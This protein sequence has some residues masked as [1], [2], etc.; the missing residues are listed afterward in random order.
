MS[1]P[2]A[3]VSL[4]T[5]DYY[6][7]GALAAAAALKDLHPTPARAPEVDFQTV[8]LVTPETV[9]VSTIKLLRRAF[10]VVVGV[11]L[12]E[13]EDE[14]GLQL[15]GRPDLSHVLTKLHVFRLTQYRKII[16]LDADVLPIRPLSHL[17]NTPHDFAAVP[18]VGWPDIF[19]SGVLVLTPGQ[20]K[21]DELVQLLKTKGSWDGG[22]QGL[23]NEWRGGNWHRLSFTY[24]TTPT[25]AYTYAPAYERFGSQISAIHFIGPNKPW[26]SLQ[27]RAPGVKTSRQHDPNVPREKRQQVYDF[28]SLIDRWFDVYDRYYRSDAPTARA[29]FE[30]RRYASAW[31][32]SGRDELGAELPP[33]TLNE[34]AAPPG[35]SL[36]LEDLRRI[37]VEGMSNMGGSTS[38]TEHGVQEGEYRSMPLEGRVDLMRP[39]PE[40]KSQSLPQEEHRGASDHRLGG[41]RDL[42]PTQEEYKQLY[43][44]GGVGHEAPRMHTLPTP[45]PSEVP[46][47]PYHHDISLPPIPSYPAQGGPWSGQQGSQQIYQ[48]HR[49]QQQQ[50]QQQ[51]PQQWQPTSEHPQGKHYHHQ[52]QPSFRHSPPPQNSSPEHEPIPIPPVYHR[53]SPG[54]SPPSHSPPYHQRHHHQHYQHH[55]HRSPPR[56]SSPPKLSWN[57]A[58]EPPPN[59]PPTVNAFPTD[60]YF[61]NIW[62]QAPSRQH[63]AAHQ[64]FPSP[65]IPQVPAPH[66]DAFFH[67]PP[68]ARI[69]EQLIQQGQYSNVF[70]HA[71]LAGPGSPSAQPVPDPT[72]VHAVF[73]WEDRPQH[74]PKRVFPASEAPPSTVKYIESEIKSPFAE[75]NAADQVQTDVGSPSAPSGIRP[76]LH[77]QPPS[78][79]TIGLPGHL[80]YANAWDT[81]PS[82]QKYASKLVRPHH[83][84]PFQH[85][86]YQSVSTSHRRSAQ[87]ADD[88]G[89]RRWE[90]ER[91]RVVQARQ[92]ASSMDGDDEDEGDDDDDSDNQSKK[93][94]DSTRGTGSHSGGRSRSGSTASATATGKAKKYRGRGV[95]TIPV[96]TRSQAVQVKIRSSSLEADGPKLRD[97]KQPPP[98]SQFATAPEKTKRDMASSPILTKAHLLPPPTLL[99][100]APVYAYRMDPDLM[101]TATPGVGQFIKQT[102]PFPSAAS[103]TGL[104]SPQTLGSPR[105]YSPPK[106]TS[107]PKAPSPPKM[108]PPKV[109]SPPRVTSPSHDMGQPTSRRMT[110]PK[111]PTPPKV[112]TPPTSGTGSPAKL[113]STPKG[114]SP[115]RLSS[116]QQQ[117]VPSRKSSFGTPPSKPASPKVGPVAASTPPPST[118]P[119]KHPKLTSPF[120]LQMS[121]SLSNETNLTS[122]PSTQGA[123]LTPESTTSSTPRRA[124]RVWDP[125]RGVDVFKRSSEEVLARFLRMGSFE[126]D[127]RRQSQIQQ[128]QE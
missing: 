44:D 49:W 104:R 34:A 43:P 127:E 66:S 53:H 63:D 92:D 18:D 78:P 122:S 116:A 40:P 19:N 12:I 21:F 10:N 121:R 3:F 85:V 26:A 90:K 112:S 119:S 96:E 114:A 65:P 42:T 118:P 25:A 125:A 72:K 1:I 97:P 38:D 73:P 128:Q 106:A 120:G 52:Y 60:T 103:P 50:Q 48:D 2:F 4:V 9:D 64:A 14:K 86:P 83:Q 98:S 88:G 76:A 84:Y 28:E 22:D 31:D 27:Y 8:C 37:A 23:L 80:T 123:P 111:V 59:D 93:D 115:R 67:P 46:P 61:P 110:P 41:D 30:V 7:P 117:F 81:V 45:G 62:D 74:I 51:Q 17:F 99:P 47:A 70:G 33:I 87:W 101:G 11:E 113:P 100:P 108:S 82:I 102:M 107:P 75:A 58:V 91:E 69:P 55:E 54:H 24:N 77:V 32:D 105:T 124:G 29:E 109:P 16:F 79:P 57:P 35:G 68:P 95:Q 36:G 39:K 56:P 15:L 126:D 6:L 13:Q 89:Y 94:K 20:D 71:P 5:S